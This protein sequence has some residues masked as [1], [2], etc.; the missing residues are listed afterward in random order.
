MKKFLP[1]FSIPSLL[2]VLGLVIFGIG[3]GRTGSKLE[4]DTSIVNE[5]QTT[6]S[7]SISTDGNLSDAVAEERIVFTRVRTF[8]AP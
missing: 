1:I 6:Q 8:G 4:A 5:S 2:V 7:S 3:Y